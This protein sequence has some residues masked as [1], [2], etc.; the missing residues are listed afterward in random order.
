MLLLV[1]NEP[2]ATFTRVFLLE[3]SNQDVKE[4][5]A[6]DKESSSLGQEEFGL[7]TRRVSVA[8]VADPHSCPFPRGTHQGFH[9]GRK[10]RATLL[11]DSKFPV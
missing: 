11:L 1:P 2:S 8:A 5:Q 7:G 4:S 9:R 10:I 3:I 6:W